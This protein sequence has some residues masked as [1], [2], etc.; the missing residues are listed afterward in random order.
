MADLGLSST[1]GVGTMQQSVRQ[2]ILDQLSR[3]QQGFQNDLELRAADRADRQQQILEQEHTAALAERAQAAATGE[4]TKL[5]PQLPMDQNVA[6]QAAGILRMGGLGGQL[7]T[8]PTAGETASGK[9]FDASTANPSMN[10]GTA[11]QQKDAQDSAAQVQIA[12]DPK[13][14]AALRGFLRVRA[15]LPKGENIPYQLITEPNGP[16]DPTKTHET[17]RLFDVAHPMPTQAP[18]P[19]PQMFT[20]PDGKQHAMQFVGGQ[21]KEIP[22]PE[23]FGKTNA[24]SQVKA[25]D[26]Q[27]ALTS[28]DQL[29][30]SIEQAKN[31]IGPGEGRI[32]SIEQTIGNPDPKIATLG[33]KLLMAKMQVD[34]GIGGARA[35]A[36]PQLLARWDSLLAQK[37]TPEALH[38]AVQAMRDILGETPKASGAGTKLSAEE[39]IKKYGGGR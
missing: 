6:P 10:L 13:T 39:L 20:G 11:P 4:A 22:L 5:A 33:A 27:R 14:P 12:N 35:A 23:G 8:P 15:T 37:L 18:N 26:R 25:E 7:Y 16:P 31:L 19:Q 38:A 1:F 2:R 21:A 28:L 9:P 29:D 30:Q 3:Q 24:A 17:N 32:S 34:A 36:S